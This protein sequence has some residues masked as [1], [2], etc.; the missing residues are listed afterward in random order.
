M[1]Q[2]LNNLQGAIELEDIG[3]PIGQEELEA[4]LE[5]DLEGGMAL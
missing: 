3:S 5:D 1:R 4:L 2:F